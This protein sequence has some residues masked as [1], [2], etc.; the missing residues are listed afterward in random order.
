MGER[1][2]NRALVG[3]LEAKRQMGRP[4]PR[5]ADDIRMDLQETTWDWINLAQNM[6]SEEFF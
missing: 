3:K 6:G 5:W 2:P 1:V 4:S